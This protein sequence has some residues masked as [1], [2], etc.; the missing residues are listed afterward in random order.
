MCLQKHGINP[1]EFNDYYSFFDFLTKNCEKDDHAHISWEYTPNK[2][3]MCGDTTG[4]WEM[5]T[6][7]MTELNP[8]DIDFITVRMEHFES[9]LGIEKKRLKQISTEANVEFILKF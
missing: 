8:D 2:K 6:N 7:K 5:F 1:A 9:E 3:H 4:R